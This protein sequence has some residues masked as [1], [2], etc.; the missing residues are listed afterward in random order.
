VPFT[1]ISLLAAATGEDTPLNLPTDTA[2]RATEAGGGSVL[3]TLVALIVVAAL[4]YAVAW[5]LKRF[6]GGA[7]P[8]KASKG[9][10]PLAAEATLALAPNRTVHVVRAGR[11]VLVLGVADGSITPLRTY[12]EQEALGLGLIAAEEDEPALVPTLPDL[13]SRKGVSFLQGGALVSRLRD[14]TVR[15]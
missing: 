6:R 9:R 5:A 10:G 13:R 11:E 15:S 7:T 4:I 3:R 2:Q 1:H 8:V 14:L 12:T